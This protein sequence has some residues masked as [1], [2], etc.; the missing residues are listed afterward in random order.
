M[1]LLIYPIKLAWRFLVFVYERFGMSGVLAVAVVLYLKFYRM[2][3]SNSKKKIGKYFTLA[4][5]TKTNKN[6]SNI[7]DA[8][9]EGRLV[10]LMQKLG[11]PVY[12]LIGGYTMNSGHRE[13]E[14]N[15]AVGGVETSDHVKSF[16]I[17][18]KPKKMT[19]SE[20]F[21]RIK[22]SALPYHQLIHERNGMGEWIHLSYSRTPS[23]KAFTLFK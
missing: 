17:D 2:Q 15:A 9:E 4:D 6:I 7:P 23:R 16:A 20:A 10:E 18:L 1:M 14:V 13:P 8:N 22:V 5:L 11:D 19:V 21:T 12:E 3:G